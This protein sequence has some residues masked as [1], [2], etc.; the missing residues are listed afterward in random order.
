MIARHESVCPSPSRGSFGRSWSLALLMLLAG[1]T[2][3]CS[4]ND[5]ASP[6]GEEDTGP[7]PILGQ[8]PEFSL[9]SHRGAS[10]GSKALGGKPYLAAFLFTRCPS[11][12]PRLTERMG[13]VADRVKAEGRTL[14]FVSISVDPEHD[15]PPVLTEFAKKH[16]ALRPNW[17]LLTGDSDAIRTT[18]ESG[19]KIGVTGAYDASK[20]D[21]GI[22]H[23]SHLIL[24]DARGRIRGFYR[25]FDDDTVA[26]VLDGLQRLTN[27]P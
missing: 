10:F 2:I 17:T 4:R 20:P 24:V 16:G 9:T 23:G 15:T 11:V 22:T 26:R 5:H 19:F 7:L 6:V 14:E 12:C 18:A 8:V 13:E 27:T 21:M 25:S 1:Q 3:A